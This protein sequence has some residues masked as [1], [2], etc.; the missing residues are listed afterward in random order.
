MTRWVLLRCDRKGDLY[1]V[2]QPSLVPHVFLTS[3]HTWHQRLRHLGSE[4]LRYV[5]S[6]NFISCNKEKPPVLCH[7]CQLGKHVRLPFTLLQQLIS[8]LHQEFSMTDLSSLNYFLGI[9]VTRDTSGMFLS[10]LKY[11]VK[12]LERAHMVNCNPIQTSV[13]TESK[14]GDD[15]D[16]VSDSTLYQNLAGSLQYLTFTRAEISYGVQQVCLYMHEP[17]EPHFSALKRILRYV[18]ATLHHGLQLFL[19]STTS[20]VAYSDADWVGFPTIG[21]STSGYGVFLGN[22]L[23]YGSSKR[24]P[25]LSRSSAETEYHGVASDVAE[26]CWLWN[27]LR[28]LPI[29]LFSTTLVYCDNVSAVYLYSNPVQHQRTKHIEIDIHFV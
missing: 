11:V 21:R 16:P 10:Q 1:P 19:S 12:I 25:T 2:M 4:V 14:L 17:R 29:P 8:S 7:A 9:F 22:N 24:Q 6:R 13:D 20:L 15:G 28:E 3:Q 26:T 18:Q 27:L 23:L 5:V